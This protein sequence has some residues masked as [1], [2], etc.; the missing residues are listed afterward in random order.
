MYI[1]FSNTP[2]PADSKGAA[3]GKRPGRR[4]V[5]STV[6]TLGIVSM[7]TD[8]SS[9]SV[10][11]I[12][13]LYVTGFLGLSTIAF[14]FL[15]GFYQGISALVRI[16]GGYTS[17]RL[18]QPKWVAFT[19]YALAAVARVGL[20]FASGFGALTAVISADRIGKGIRTAPR[21][22]VITASSRPDSLGAAF[23]MHRM[24]DNIGAAIGPLLAFFILLLIPDGYGTIFVASLGFAVV[25]VTL[26]GLFVP[27]VR[28]RAKA[29]AGK[30]RLRLPSVAQPVSSAEASPPPLNDPQASKP[31]Q[32]KFDWSVIT[33]GPMRR[34]LAAAGILG[35]LTIGDG[36]IYLVL[37]TRGGFAAQWFPLMYVGTNIAFL[38]LAIPL[39]R[40][41][42]R[43]GRA[44]VFVVGHA[45]LLGAYLVAVMPMA[46]VAATILCL[47]L[48]GAFYAATDG[49]LAALAAQLTTPET[50]GT[51][52]AA[53]QTVVALSR[54][55]SASGFGI[56]WFLVG[57]EIAMIVVAAM[58]LVAIPLIAWLL[59]AHLAAPTVADPQETEQTP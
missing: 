37:Q 3:R 20:L 22:A 13:P 8:I 56:L 27:N 30:E 45:G 54:F 41:A 33:A 23:G 17:D 6:V 2:K 47:V 16:A 40:L 58:L 44:R 46:D 32:P 19:G 21:D 51:G 31:R 18:D 34:V 25:G 48:L 28:S 50:R 59:R 9:E 43:V 55:A 7:L 53:A 5:S 24:L 57:R 35:L 10:T 39:G 4:T 26:L 12:L 38:A 49:V 1:S 29:C 11:A 36:F 15:D 52:I 42:D 14:G